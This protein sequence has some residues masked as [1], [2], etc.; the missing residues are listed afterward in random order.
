MR[1]MN[2]TPP[3]AFLPAALLRDGH[4][5]S[6]Q[7]LYLIIG[8]LVAVIIVGGFVFYQERHKSG[9]EA[10]IGNKGISVETH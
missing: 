8:V 7:S 3:L 4:A 10:E 9:I 2:R 6:G 1:P 5:Q